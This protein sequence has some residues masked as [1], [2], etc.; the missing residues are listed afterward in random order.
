MKRFSLLVIFYSII[1][2]NYSLAQWVQ[3][4]TGMGTDQIINAFYVNGNILYAGTYSGIYRSTN[5]G[6]SWTSTSINNKAVLSFAPSGNNLYAGTNISGVLLSTD[7]GVSWNQTGLN[8]QFVYSVAV[9]NN[10]V[11]AGTGG[12]GIFM[13][14]NYGTNW[15][16]TLV[17][18][19]DI[20][21]FVILNNVVFAGCYGSGVYVSTDNGTT[22]ALSNLS[23]PVY[24]LG[25]K[26]NVVYAGVFDLYNVSMRG[27]YFTTNNG[28]GWGMTGLTE[29]SV[30]SFAFSGDNILAGT[31]DFGVFNTTNNGVSWYARNQGFGI[32]PTVSALLMYNN[33]VFAGTYGRSVW[34]CAASQILNSEK[35]YSVLPTMYFLRQNYPNPFNP[36]TRIDFDIPRSGYVNLKVFDIL[37]REVK[38]LVKEDKLAGSYSVDFNATDLTSGVYFYKMESEEYTD[39]KRMVL[40]K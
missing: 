12:Q 16:Q 18:N 39:V 40:I 26:G 2:L 32:T 22:W 15:T 21:S 7:Y 19:R 23:R 6:N 27:V 31:E 20:R 4:G 14:T 5:N 35:I 1:V 10:Y 34:R 38:T 29:K 8:N 30:R 11:Y 24:A 13:S 33:Y 25:S 9:N 28:T 17:N 3:I 36:V 37:G